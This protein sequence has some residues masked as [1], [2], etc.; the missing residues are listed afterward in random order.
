MNVNIYK[1]LCVVLIF[2][3]RLK[4]L[5]LKHFLKILVEIFWG[6][7][8]HFLIHETAILC[9]K[10]LLHDVDVYLWEVSRGSY[11]DILALEILSPQFLQWNRADRSL[12]II[13]LERSVGDKRADVLFEL[14]QERHDVWLWENEAFVV[15]HLGRDWEIEL[16]AFEHLNHHLNMLLHFTEHTSRSLSLS[17]S[18]EKISKNYSKD[19]YALLICSMSWLHSASILLRMS[20]RSSS[21]ILL[22]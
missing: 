18:T 4:G 2:R 8:L 13:A 11:S 12:G 7:K 6:S 16:R 5:V 14:G 22:R 17:I 21:L 19:T 1:S 20:S 9:L 10:L 3:H 15:V